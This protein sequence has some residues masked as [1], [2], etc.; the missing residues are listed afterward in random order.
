MPADNGCTSREHPLALL[1][2][3]L[4]D[5]EYPPPATD[6]WL[7][8]V[9]EFLPIGLLFILSMLW[10][11]AA[12]YLLT[13]AGAFAGVQLS[14][15]YRRFTQLL[16]DH[17]AEA[18]EQHVS[19]IAWLASKW[20]V[21]NSPTYIH[22]HRAVGYSPLG[23]ARARRRYLRLAAVWP[24]YFTDTVKSGDTAD[25]MLTAPVAVVRSKARTDQ[26]DDLVS[27][28]PSRP[29]RSRRGITRVLSSLLAAEARIY[30][31]ILSS[32]GVRRLHQWKIEKLLSTIGQELIRATRR[33][34]GDAAVRT[35][36]GDLGL[37]YRTPTVSQQWVID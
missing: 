11:P 8:V 1:A 6:S 37:D 5:L 33:R 35:L 21:A 30:R 9:L 10:R 28:D 25:H 19:A 24:R 7:R 22:D 18:R 36:A 17:F 16:S 13:F 14:G 4:G 34:T 15:P 29:Q 2:D 20:D 27:A 31:S 32:R 26:F 3:E 12:P 23:L